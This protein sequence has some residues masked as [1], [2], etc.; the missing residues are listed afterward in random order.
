MVLLLVVVFRS[1]AVWFIHIFNMRECEFECECLCMY[2]GRRASLLGNVYVYQNKRKKK[3]KK[4][5]TF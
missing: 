4:N 3:E 5:S 2:L 1:M